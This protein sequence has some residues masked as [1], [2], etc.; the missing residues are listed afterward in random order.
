MALS[1]TE[2]ATKYENFLCPIC[3]SK[4]FQQ[5]T[6]SNGIYGPGGRTWRDHCVCSG[7]SVVFKNPEKFTKAKKE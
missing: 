2:Q 4:D 5:E 7:C 1:G 3:G 6:K